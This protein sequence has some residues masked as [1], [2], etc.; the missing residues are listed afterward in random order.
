VTVL[1][2]FLGLISYGSHEL[3]YRVYLYMGLNCSSQLTAYSVINSSCV[4]SLLFRLIL[5]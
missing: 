1:S 2:V 4:G 3:G 5:C